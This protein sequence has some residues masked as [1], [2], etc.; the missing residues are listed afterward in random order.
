VR[1]AWAPY[2]IAGAVG[3]ALIAVLAAMLGG[4]DG[5]GGDRAGGSGGTAARTSDE[6]LRRLARALDEGDA[7]AVEA[8]VVSTRRYA[9]VISCDDDSMDTMR[10]TMREF[11]EEQRR[12]L[13]ERVAR[14]EGRRPSVEDVTETKDEVHHAGEEAFG[15]CRYRIE[16][17]ERNVDVRL[18][19]RDD[20][21]DRVLHTARVEMVGLEGRWYL[22]DVSDDPWGT[23]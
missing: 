16:W 22:I 14:W 12:K 18:R 3:I 9:D 4:D 10:R 13:R 6:L 20:D 11:E 21:G 19:Y 5:G 8:M 17:T 7:D 15:Q 2:A 1:R 23:P